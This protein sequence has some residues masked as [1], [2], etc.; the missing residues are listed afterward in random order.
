MRNVLL[1]FSL[2]LAVQVLRSVIANVMHVEMFKMEWWPWWLGG[3][4]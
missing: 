3:R 2:N 4:V 1:C